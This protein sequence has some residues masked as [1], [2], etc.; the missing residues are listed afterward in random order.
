M[1]EDNFIV[2]YYNRILSDTCMNYFHIKY[3]KDGITWYYTLI[4]FFKPI[5]M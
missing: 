4:F 2:F 3:E 1:A 5:I